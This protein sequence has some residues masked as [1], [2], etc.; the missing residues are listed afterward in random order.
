VTKSDGEHIERKYAAA[1]QDLVNSGRYD[2]KKDFT[3]VIQ[4]FLREMSLS[5]C[6]VSSIFSI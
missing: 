3:V 6:R 4:P 1:I 2:T 5:T